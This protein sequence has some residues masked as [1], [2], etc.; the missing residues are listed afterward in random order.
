MCPAPPDG[1]MRPGG[2]A[3]SASSCT[4]TSHSNSAV[5]RCSRR[6]AY[7]LTSP[8]TCTASALTRRASFA[9]S[10]TTSPPRMISPAPRARSD[11]SRSRRQ[12][13]RNAARLGRLNP[14]DRIAASSTNTGTTRW[15][16]CTAC[17]KT[18]LSCTRRSRVNST[19]PMLT[20]CS[21]RGQVGVRGKVGAGS[22][23]S[24]PTRSGASA[25]APGRRRRRGAGPRT[26]FP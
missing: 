5:S 6:W 25:S 9:V 19:T 10:A 22:A 4:T 1:R 2:T 13:A 17:H 24:A 8:A 12:S 7:P 16:E 20:P 23:A 15:W 11:A 21:P 14:P 18:G 3:N 26:V